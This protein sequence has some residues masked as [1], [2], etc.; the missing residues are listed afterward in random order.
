MTLRRVLAIGSILLASGALA[1]LVSAE[2]VAE[3]RGPA[4]VVFVCRN[5]VA[6]SVWSAAY[7]NRLAA[8]RGIPER[9][10]GRA[11]VPSFSDVP[12]RMAFA[13]DQMG[14]KQ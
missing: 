2:P 6:M 7:F 9:A 3:A 11:S 12:L 5:G 13:L 10:I 14:I 8:A 4:S 1:F